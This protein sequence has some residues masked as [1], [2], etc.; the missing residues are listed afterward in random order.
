MVV[1]VF[2]IQG[3][4]TLPPFASL[5]QHAALGVNAVA[6]HIGRALIE[7]I[8]PAKHTLDPAFRQLRL[9]PLRPLPD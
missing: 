6:K 5:S 8:D 2:K 4:V 3:D 7:R 9:G 1:D